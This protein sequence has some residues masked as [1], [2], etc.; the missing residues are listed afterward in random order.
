MKITVTLSGGTTRQLSMR[1]PSAEDVVGTGTP[2]K[3][4]ELAL[5]ANL[6]GVSQDTIRNLPEADYTRVRKAFLA[7]EKFK[8]RDHATG[9]TVTSP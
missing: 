3:E 7:I 9:P 1:A 2:T 6:C 4:Q 5:F 8:A